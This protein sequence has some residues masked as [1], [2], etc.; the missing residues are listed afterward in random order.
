MKKNLHR[1]KKNWMS[2]LTSTQTGTKKLT[3]MHAQVTSPAGDSTTGLI[4]VCCQFIFKC[5]CVC[6]L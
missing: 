2:S 1:Q 6:V 4:P 5:V 3:H